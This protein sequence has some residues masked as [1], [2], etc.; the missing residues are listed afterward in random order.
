MLKY[1]TS[2]ATACGDTT[3]T[4][5]DTITLPAGTRSIIGVWVHAMAGPGF[6]TLENVTGF[7]ELESPDINL[8]PCQV[9]L[10]PVGMLTGGAVSSQIHTWPLN[11]SVKGSERISGYITMDMAQTVANKARFGLVVDVA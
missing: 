5:I 2:L 3:K 7:L 11:A 1:L 4:L 8:Q 10:E 9:P 6:T